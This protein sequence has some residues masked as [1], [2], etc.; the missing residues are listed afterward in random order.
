MLFQ[1]QCLPNSH[2]RIC[3]QFGELERFV[4]RELIAF[5]RLRQAFAPIGAHPMSKYRDRRPQRTTKTAAAPS[6]LLHHTL[7]IRS[8]RV[9]LSNFS[10]QFRPTQT[11]NTGFLP[12]SAPRADRTRADDSEQISPP[13]ITHHTVYEKTRNIQRNPCLSMGNTFV[14]GRSAISSRGQT[15]F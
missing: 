5:E 3:L 4:W 12:L 6:E 7:D 14:P 13:P 15:S 9:M 10:T 1:R 11:R 2:I 8:T